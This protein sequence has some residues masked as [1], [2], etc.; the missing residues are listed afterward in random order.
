MIKAI[1][2]DSG[3]VIGKSKIGVYDIIS[4]KT[5]ISKEKVKE[6]IK[7]IIHESQIKEIEENVFWKRV[8]GRLGT[9]LKKDSKKIS[10]AL[11][12]FEIDKG[13]IG[14]IRK[15][16]KYKRGLISNISSSYIKKRANVNN[17]FNVVIRSCEIGYRKPS[18]E[19]YL[20]ALKELGVNPKETVY[21]DDTKDHVEMAEN[22]GLKGIV[23]KNPDQL[24]KEL[25]KL[26]IL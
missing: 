3:N 22:L 9:T 15:L 2:F 12:Y 4:N 17:L 11:S 26:K 5:K 24:R 19:I 25:K 13:V 14:I 21:V 8:D 7:D 18:K 16:G 6:S 23:Y 20:L 1:I 10:R